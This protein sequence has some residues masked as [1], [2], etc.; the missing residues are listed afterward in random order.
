MGLLSVLDYYFRGKIIINWP[1]YL[2][3]LSREYLN[4]KDFLVRLFIL[5][6]KITLQRY[7][8]INI[9]FAGRIKTKLKLQFFVLYNLDKTFFFLILKIP[10]KLQKRSSNYIKKSIF[11]NI[12]AKKKVNRLCYTLLCL[13]KTPVHQLAISP[14]DSETFSCHSVLLLST[15]V[16]RAYSHIMWEIGLIQCSLISN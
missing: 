5:V 6:R 9:P 16:E 12:Y 8:G 15:H 13:L 1:I 11:K 4:Q 14:K 2:Y 3:F 10:A 7:R